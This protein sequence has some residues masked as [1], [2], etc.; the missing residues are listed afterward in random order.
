M[1]VVGSVKLDREGGRE[2]ASM[3]V[4]HDTI[5]AVVVL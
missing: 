5:L 1:G 2:E 3:A 4:A